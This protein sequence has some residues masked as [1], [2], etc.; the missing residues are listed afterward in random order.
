MT[1]EKKEL[2]PTEAVVFANQLQ[3]Q[4]IDAVGA[5]VSLPNNGE[6]TG[7]VLDDKITCQPTQSGK[8]LF[9]VRCEFMVNGQTKQV[10]IPIPPKYLAYAY[11]GATIVV[12]T[13]AGGFPAVNEVKA[14][15]VN[16]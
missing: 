8:A 11:R 9:R 16:A 7:Y 2:T 15:T 14:A 12:K 10:S 6:F 3:Q 1:F 5:F 4:G 13:T